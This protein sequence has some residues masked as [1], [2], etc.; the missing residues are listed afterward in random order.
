MCHYR[1]NQR[2]EY[3]ASRADTPVMLI[4]VETKVYAVVHATFPTTALNIHSDLNQVAY[5]I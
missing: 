3:A 5:K 1:W 2:T 4:P